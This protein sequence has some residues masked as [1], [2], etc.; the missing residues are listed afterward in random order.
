M[1]VLPP[2]IRRRLS[3]R[4]GRSQSPVAW[5]VPVRGMTLT[6]RLEAVLFF[7]LVAIVLDVLIMPW[8][9]DTHPLLHVLQGHHLRHPLRVTRHATP[10][11]RHL[12]ALALTA[13]VAAAALAHE[14]G[15]ALALRRAGATE[16]EIV[17]YG[18][19]GAC[20]AQARDTSP[21]ALLWYAAAGPIVTI[22]L[23]IGMLVARLALPWPH[24]ARAIFWLCAATQV[25][26]LACNVLPLIA[27]SDGGH[28]RR[29][30]AALPGAG[31]GARRVLGIGISLPVLTLFATLQGDPR[32]ALL[33]SAVTL[34]LTVTLA[35]L[36]QGTQ[37]GV[38]QSRNESEASACPR[39]SIVLL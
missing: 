15:H 7:V 25:G 29:A 21:A 33:W 24:P 34:L 22:A 5:R 17:L 14:L 26:I 1:P 31:P 19:G 27:R 36:A 35:H 20:R 30:I 28:M 32:A 2:A 10:P 13:L 39:P 3:L 37:H 4:A 18:A 11:V 9:L 23:V 16:I 38:T 12:G 8:A 6:I